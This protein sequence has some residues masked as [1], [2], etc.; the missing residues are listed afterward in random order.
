MVTG[1]PGICPGE[2]AAQCSSGFCDTNRSSNFGQT[3]DSQQKKE[4]LPNSG[5]CRPADN[6]VKSPTKKTKKQKKQ[7]KTKK[8]RKE[9]K[10]SR[11][12]LRTKRA[13]GHEGAGDTICNWRSWNKPHRLGEGTG[14]LGN[15]RTSGDHP[16]YNTVLLRSVRI[17]RRV[18]ETWG[19]VLSQ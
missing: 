8:K 9:R 17:P 4:N 2:W 14:S 10:I 5:L 13:M 18:Q 12:C 11:S 3:S 7:N 6:W 1:Q 15:K 19:N 16:D